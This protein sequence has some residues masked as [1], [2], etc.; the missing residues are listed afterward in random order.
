MKTRKSSKWA[1]RTLKNNMKTNLSPMKTWRCR[2]TMTA[3]LRVRQPIF[4]QSLPRST[5]SSS[6]SYSTSRTTW[7]ISHMPRIP[8]I[9]GVLRQWILTWGRK[10]A[11]NV[12]SPKK[13][14]SV[15][16]RGTVPSSKRSRIA[17]SETTHIS[18]TP[19]R[20]K[21]CRWADRASRYL[22]WIRG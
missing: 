8:T 18:P 7:T 16:E 12:Y 20:H 21:D 4:T 15:A 14:V 9:S 2:P 10:E 3:F 13:S 1:I 5:T 17:P 11:S 6:S 19:I 22:V